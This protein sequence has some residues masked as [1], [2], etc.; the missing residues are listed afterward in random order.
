MYEAF[1]LRGKT[2]CGAAFLCGSLCS[3]G[4]GDLCRKYLEKLEKLDF[5]AKA[6]HS[7]PAA[8][9]RLQA[10]AVQQCCGREVLA[11]GA[12]LRIPGLAWRTGG[13]LGSPAM[14][15]RPAGSLPEDIGHGLWLYASPG[16]P[17]LVCRRK[18]RE[19]SWLIA[20]C[21]LSLSG[22][23]RRLYGKL[24]EKGLRTF[25]G[26]SDGSGPGAE[27]VIFGAAGK[28]HFFENLPGGE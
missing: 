12:T 8:V 18:E 1:F 14:A 25:L 15:V 16:G 3:P 17:G 19:I 28:R 24:L 4:S 2:R 13:V 26:I 21:G 7:D 11:A 20:A 27:G 10:A 6:F 9:D 5:S 22:G 23:M